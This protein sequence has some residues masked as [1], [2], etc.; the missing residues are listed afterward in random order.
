MSGTDAEDGEAPDSGGVP[1]AHRAA[2]ARW[3]PWRAWGLA[4]GLG[5]WAA[6]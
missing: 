6:A 4:G 2:R 1:A 3:A 5:C